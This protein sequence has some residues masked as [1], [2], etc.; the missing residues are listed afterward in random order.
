MYMIISREEYFSQLF[1]THCNNIFPQSSLYINEFYGTRLKVKSFLQ[2]YHDYIAQQYSQAEYITYRNLF[3]NFPF[4]GN[5]TETH[6]F[7][8]L[9]L[10]RY[11][12]PTE[13]QLTKALSNF[14]LKNQQSCQAF[15]QAIFT[16]LNK[17]DIDLC[18]NYNCFCEVI[19]K[20]VSSRKKKRKRIDNVIIWNNE[21][22]CIEVKFDAVINDNDL[23]TYEEQIEKDS[24]TKN[25]N[26][27]Y[28]AISI[29]NIKDALEQKKCENWKNLYWRDVLRLWEENIFTNNIRE[30]DDMIRYRSSLWNKI[31]YWEN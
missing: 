29:N 25:K 15:L 1:E 17:K 23:K 30:S 5:Y 31:L 8:K 26:K 19:T 13:P 20:D 28:V 9:P 18:G 12:N 22:L 16:L 27:T 6:S 7:R 3:S 24:R 14:L 4:L 21:V 2:D 10:Y 11:I